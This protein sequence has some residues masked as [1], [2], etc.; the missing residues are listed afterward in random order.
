VAA[1]VGAR[2]VTIFGVTERARTGPWSP[3]AVCVGANGAW[4]AVA[5]VV[6]AIDAALAR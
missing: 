5:A 4:P 6:A 2:Q 3:R 1:A